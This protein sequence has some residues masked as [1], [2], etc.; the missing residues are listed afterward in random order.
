MLFL[1]CT[2]TN[3]STLD[4]TKFI[5]IVGKWQDDNSTIEYFGD[6]TF[7]GQWGNKAATGIWQVHKDT[8]KI[9][10]VFGYEP[11]YIITEYTQDKMVIK[12]ITDGEVFTKVRI[13]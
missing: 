5:N 2:C 9:K 7:K 1:F 11:Y 10:F 8:L 4:S 6:G 13:E 3:S 12:S